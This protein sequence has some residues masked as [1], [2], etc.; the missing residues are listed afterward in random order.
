MTGNTNHII[1]QL[2]QADTL[3]KVS[4]QDLENITL[5]YPYFNAGHYLFCRKLK[6]ENNYI[7]PEKTQR[8]ALYFTNPFWMQWLLKNAQDEPQTE[9]VGPE[10]A[11]A[12][13]SLDVSNAPEN[14]EDPLPNSQEV[15]EAEPQGPA[16]QLLTAPATVN[17]VPPLFE[18]YHTID[19]FASQGIKFVQE[20]NPSDKLG[21]Q[22]KSFTEWLRMM[23]R[24][25]QDPIPVTPENTSEE[26]IETNAAE[27]IEEKEVLTETWA[28][29]LVKQGKTQNALEVYRKLSL[30]N[31]DKSAYFAARIEQLNV[32]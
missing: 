22:L 12:P 31:P 20:T 17:T 14:R 9:V 7:P 30:L 26:S 27:S 19:Y 2:F 24:L 28:E 21:K 15:P 29:V 18:P 13:I 4:L 32:N 5:E 3:E 25:P 8:S 6:I 10:V 16:D 23:K 1:R 11:F